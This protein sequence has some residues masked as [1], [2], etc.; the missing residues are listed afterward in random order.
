MTSVHLALLWLLPGE[1]FQGDFIISFLGPFFLFS[2]FF[3]SFFFLGSCLG[4]SDFYY[5]WGRELIRYFDD[6]FIY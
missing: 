1:V 5:F 3:F 4:G 6:L 2:F